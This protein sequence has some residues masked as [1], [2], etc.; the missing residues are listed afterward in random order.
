MDEKLLKAKPKK[1]VAFFDE[2]SK[3]AVIIT[4]LY[5]VGN[6]IMYWVSL[7]NGLKPSDAV[8]HDS[9]Q[10]IL[11]P[12]LGYIMRTV[13]L[14][15]SLNRYGLTLTEDGKTEKVEGAAG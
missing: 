14:K 13:F 7:A 1:R 12:L 11:V 4:F 10:L 6:G 15:H 9:V 8:M 2:F 5:G 3:V